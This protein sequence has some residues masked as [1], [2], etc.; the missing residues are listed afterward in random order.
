MRNVSF[1]YFSTPDGDKL[2]RLK[3]ADDN[4]IPHGCYFDEDEISNH[5]KKRLKQDIFPLLEFLSD[6]R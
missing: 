5:I 6:S 4:R 1:K 3:G 2:S